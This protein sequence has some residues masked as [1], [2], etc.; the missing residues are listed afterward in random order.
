VVSSLSPT[1]GP[2]GGATVVTVIG[3]A[4]MPDSW[5]SI[6]STYAIAAYA[7]TSTRLLCTTPAGA[8]GTAPLG[9]SINSADYVVATSPFLYYST[10]QASE[11]V[12]D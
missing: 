3:S 1:L 10:L 6:G 4:F 12:G 8:A 2:L 7:V 5:C 11:F 9:V